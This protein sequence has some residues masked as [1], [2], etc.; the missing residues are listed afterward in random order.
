MTR[1]KAHN[2]TLTIQQGPQDLQRDSQRPYVYH[3]LLQSE[4][5]A[6]FSEKNAQKRR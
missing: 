6:G 5:L 3:E 1:E 2:F 4:S